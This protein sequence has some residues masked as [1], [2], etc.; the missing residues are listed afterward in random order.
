MGRHERTTPAELKG[1][2]RN[3]G[4]KKIAISNAP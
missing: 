4:Y 1:Y 3:I 2:A